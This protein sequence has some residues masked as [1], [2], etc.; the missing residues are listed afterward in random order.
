MKIP[1][2]PRHTLALGLSRTS[3]SGWYASSRLVY[4]SER[5]RDQA[6]IERLRPGWDGAMD[7]YWQPP[8]SDWLLRFSVDD[9][10]D[11]DADTLYTIDASYR[12]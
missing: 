10:F 11:R 7:V 12:F 3:P 9:M 5:F 2:L 4:R 8:K 6:N 1:F